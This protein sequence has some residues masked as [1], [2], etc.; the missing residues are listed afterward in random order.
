MTIDIS[1]YLEP[2]G[3]KNDN[4]STEENLE[5]KGQGAITVLSWYLSGR[6][7]KNHKKTV[8]ITGVL[9]E[10]WTWKYPSTI[11]GPCVIHQWRHNPVWTQQYLQ[12]V[13][14]AADCGPTKVPEVMEDF[15]YDVAV[16][17]QIKEI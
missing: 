9:S 15:Q 6:A 13:D 4:W 17:T 2:Y 12:E 5:G 14:V 3:R 11:S 7:V 8:M 16:K 10:D 1:I